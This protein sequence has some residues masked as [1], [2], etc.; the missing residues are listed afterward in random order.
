MPTSEQ[1]FRFPCDQCGADLRFQPGSDQM[2]CDNCGATKDLGNTTSATPILERDFDAALKAG[3]SDA[4][5]E[6]TRFTKCENCGAEIEF[7]EELQSTECP[8][9]AS[10]I[11]LGTGTH[12]L[13]K[14]AAVLPFAKSEKE[15]RGAMTKWL[16]KLWFAPNGLQ[17]YARKGRAM[18][19]IYVPF[20]TYDAD[21][22]SRYKG[23]RGT[24]YY[25]TR[26]VRVKVDGKMVNQQQQVQRIRWRAASG[27]V[28]RFFDDILVLGSNSLPKANTDGLAPWDLAALE[29]YAPEYLAGFQAEG[30]T[31][32][33]EDGYREARTIMDRMIERDVRFDIGGDRQQIDRIDTTISDVTFKHILLPV[34][35]AAYKYRGKTYRFVV[36]GRTGTVQGERPYSKVKIAIAVVFGAIVAGVVG[37]FIAQ[38][39]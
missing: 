29:P 34:W 10:P 13:I 19:G 8:F 25:E 15:A 22:K 39:R 11:V 36:N 6:E 16:G 4:E 18:Q 32:P 38:N 2:V 26:T 30:Y 5:V 33:L 17:E 27:R 3:D 20:W 7:A 1:E 23:Q 12:R 9:C 31:V 37:Y 14:P 35:L 21:T 24:I 28:A